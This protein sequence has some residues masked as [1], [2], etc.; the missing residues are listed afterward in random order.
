VGGVVDGRELE[1]F[2]FLSVG[3]LELARLDIDLMAGDL[4]FITLR[5]YSSFL[6]IPWKPVDP[7]SLQNLINAGG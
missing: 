3:V 6:G 1:T 2:Q 5:L 4:L 7:A